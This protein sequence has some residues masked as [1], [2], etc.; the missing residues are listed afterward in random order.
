M[1]NNQSCEMGIEE[2]IKTAIANQNIECEFIPCNPKFADTQQFCE[3]YGYP[4]VNSAN[5]IIVAS[6]REP[7]SFAACVASATRKLDIN[8]TIRKLLGVRHLSFATPEDTYNVTGMMIGGVTIFGL[9]ETIPIYI[10]SQVL[11]LDYVIFGGG[12]RSLKIKMNPYEIRKIHQIQF[13]NGLA[14]DNY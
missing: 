4:P 7:K 5:T 14:F 12:S 3:H 13:I 1:S 8:K 6:R 9:P 10:D 11:S 2:I